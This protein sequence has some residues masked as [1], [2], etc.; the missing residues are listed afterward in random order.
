MADDIKFCLLFL[1]SED[2]VGISIILFV[3][4]DFLGFCLLVLV[5]KDC[6]DL[7]LIFLTA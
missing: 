5:A 7:C 2:C 6:V 1:D 4:E 3:V